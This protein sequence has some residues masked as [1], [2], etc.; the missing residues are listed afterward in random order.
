M[1]TTV[2]L[3]GVA[4]AM[5]A[6]VAC[7][8]G[9]GGGGGAPPG[10]GGGSSTAWVPGVFPP[11][12]NFKDLCENPRSGTNPSSG[13]P[14]PDIQGDTVDENNWLR[15][16]SNDTYLWYDEIADVD[17]ASYNDPVDYF[18]DE[19]KTFELT[20]SGTEKDQ[21]H[22]V[23][24]TD[25]WIALSQSGVSLGY[26][27]NW[28][29]VSAAPP[30]E[31]VVIYSDAGTPAANAGFGRGD[32][33]LSIDGVDVVNDNTQA[34]VNTINGALFPETVGESHEFEIEDLGTRSVTAHQLT[35]GQVTSVPVQH[36]Q[37][38]ASPGGATVGYLLFNDHIATAEQ[39]LIDA[40][41]TLANVPGGIDDLVLDIRYNGGGFLVIASQ[42]AYMIAGETATTGRVFEETEFNDKHPTI[43][44]VTGAAIMP[45]PF[46]GE[47]VGLSAPATNPP[48]LLPTLDLD[49]VFVLTGGSTCSA[50]ESVINGLRGVGIEVIQIG[51]TTCGKPYGFY[52]TDNCGTTYFTIQMRGAND[53]GFGDYVDGF[54]PSGSTSGTPV[55][56]PGCVVPDDFEHGFGD[57]DEAR[58]ATALYYR[59]NSACPTSPLSPKVSGLSKTEASVTAEPLIVKPEGL[60]N[61]I[62]GY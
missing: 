26:G 40:V 23:Y 3:V 45:L 44:P 2:S 22:F 31:I 54:T 37:T 46:V 24:D 32:R 14:W 60:T 62:L 25:E 5:L 6:L 28:A 15:S 58:L 29:I 36:V 7:G 55:Q 51:T 17:P 59:D 9:G 19:L 13:A 52:P 38:V 33:I 57:P 4:I 53:A 48:T 42:L 11:A 61:R 39:A 47:T 12:A 1:R 41:E 18:L 21:F 35:A 27:F 49:R 34:G 8:G 20:L 16:W 56:P 50:S 10:G 30:R 43:N